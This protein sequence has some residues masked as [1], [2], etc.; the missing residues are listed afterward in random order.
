[1]GVTMEYGH[2]LSLTLLQ[3]FGVVHVQVF[4]NNLV[5]FGF[6]NLKPRFCGLT[7]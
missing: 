2:S 5:Q 7:V 6:Y 4:L 1:M 3:R